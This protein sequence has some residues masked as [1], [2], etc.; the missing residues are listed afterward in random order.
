MTAQPHPDEVPRMD[1][2]PFP[3]YY[4]DT[5]TGVIG[6][7]THLVFVDVLPDDLQDESDTTIVNYGKEH[8]TPLDRLL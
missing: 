7:P 3:A 1:L 6:D 8:G 5:E 2:Q 4:I